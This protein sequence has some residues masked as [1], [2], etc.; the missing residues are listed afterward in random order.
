MA[1]ITISWGLTALA[2][3]LSTALAAAF[4]ATPNVLI[5]TCAVIAAAFAVFAI[6]SRGAH[7]ASGA[8]R[9][10]IAAASARAMALV[11]IWG[12][13]AIVITYQLI[14]PWREWWHFALAFAIA[15]TACLFFSNVHERDAAAR[16]DDE[17]MLKLGRGL[18]MAQLLGTL[19]AMVGLILDPN[20]TFQDTT[21]PAWAA[22]ILFFAGAAALAA[23][24]A[25]AILTD[26]LPEA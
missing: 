16:R 21:D 12:A 24:S 17:T 20:K 18:A 7:A 15:G 10:R 8:S 2:L 9:S 5:A 23:I 1:G 19:A 25:H 14:P 6:R 4:G 3:A 13:I 22:N 26:R 11:W